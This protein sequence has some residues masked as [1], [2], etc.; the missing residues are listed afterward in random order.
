LRSD[1]QLLTAIQHGDVAAFDTLVARFEA[2]VRRR[3]VR[4]VRDHSVAEDVAQDVFLRVWMRADQWSGRGTVRAW[5]LQ[6]AT[7]LA[8]NA[9]RARRRQRQRLLDGG[10]DPDGEEQAAAAPGW[11]IDESALGPDEAAE[12]AEQCE[13]LRHLV[14]DL[15]DP[16][17]EV[18]RLIYEEQMTVRQAAEALGIPEGTVKSR[19]HYAVR[20]L[21]RAWQNIESDWE[22]G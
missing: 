2:S 20:R 10:H 3:V 6:I 21:A 19:L 18:C 22:D 1:Q 8:L 14:G 17:R 7:N 15:S 11:M 4:V 9:L 5:L 12:L 13:L 16:M